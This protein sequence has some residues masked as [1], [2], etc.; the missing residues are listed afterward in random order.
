MVPGIIGK[1]YVCGLKSGSEAL[2]VEAMWPHQRARNTAWVTKRLEK[3]ISEA[4]WSCEQ[5]SRRIGFLGQETSDCLSKRGSTQGLSDLR[6]RFQCGSA[7]FTPTTGYW[8]DL[9]FWCKHHERPSQGWQEDRLL[10]QD[11]QGAP[12]MSFSRQFPKSFHKKV[13]TVTT[14]DLSG[15]S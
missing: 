7:S 2:Q 1:L 13:L 8:P 4:A 12:E 14:K 5:E 3:L 10:T 6:C 15:K 9:S 11:P